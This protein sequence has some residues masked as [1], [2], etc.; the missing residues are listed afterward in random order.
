MTEQEK[1]KNLEM[2]P[3]QALFD[4]AITKEV[5]EAEIKGKDKS[6][7]IFKLIHE[8]ML[9]DSEIERLVNDY[10]YGDRVSFTLWNFENNLTQEQYD[11]IYQLEGETEA[12]LPANG[13]RGL[14]VLSVKNCGD[15]IEVL[16]VYSKEYQY[17]SEEGKSDSIWEQHRGCLWIGV[18]A[19]Y[20]ACISKH[21]KMT[22][23][24]VNY[25][26]GKVG[27]SLTQ[28]KP[29]KSA[30]ERCINQV[31]RSR[32]VLQGTDGEKTVVSRSEGL[33]AA[34]QEEITRIQ[35]DRFDTSGSYIASITE[36]T[37]ATVKYNVKKD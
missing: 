36:D 31:A 24:V 10:I 4:L 2:L 22:G 14:T 5:D 23:C 7:I 6:V 3:W 27:T 1:R 20:L 32:V 34:Q 16:Y 18:D 12:F 37:R 30:I 33:T 25:I 9:S 29:P 21:D 19:A 28:V 8:A 17:I 15:R 35:G 13:F 26:V 11:R